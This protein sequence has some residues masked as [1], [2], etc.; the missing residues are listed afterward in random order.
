MILDTLPAGQY[1]IRVTAQNESGYS[2][3]AFDYYVTDIGKH[4]GVKCFYVLED[5]TVEEDVYEE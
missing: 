3:T 4:Y 2:Q 5:G 1:F